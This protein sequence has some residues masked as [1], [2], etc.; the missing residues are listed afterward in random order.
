[1]PQRAK[2]EIEKLCGCYLAPAFC[3]HASLTDAKRAQLE[4]GGRI[5]EPHQCQALHRT[6]PMF[7]INGTRYC[8]QCAAVAVDRD[9]SGLRG[10]KAYCHC[11]EADCSHPVMP[12][13][14]RLTLEL[15][16]PHQCRNLHGNNKR[17]RGRGNVLVCQFCKN[18]A[19]STT[20]VPQEA[21]A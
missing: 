5:L 8:A 6:E 14:D 18:H 20:E 21:A 19:V 7:A 2:S 4:S 12:E 3:Q 11:S 1:M 15:Q 17:F 16:S 10:A 9:P 13:S